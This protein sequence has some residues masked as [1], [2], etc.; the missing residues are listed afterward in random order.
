[1]N[2]LYRL[3]LLLTALLVAD[4]VCAQSNAPTGLTVNVTY[5]GSICL[6]WKPNVP[7][8]TVYEIERSPNGRSGSFIKV[9]ES[10]AVAGGTLAV[11][12]Y[13]DENLPSNTTYYYQVRGKTGTTFTG[14]SNTTPGTTKA[15]PPT[16]AAPTLSEVTTTDIKVTW[17]TQFATTYELE[18][19]TGGGAWRVINTQGSGRNSSL[20]YK[21]TTLSG[22]VNY[23]FRVRAN[24]AQEGTSGYSP[25]ACQTTLQAASNVRNFAANANGSSNSIK[26]T[27]DRYGKESGITIERRTG[28][29]GAWDKSFN[30]LADGGE[31]TDTGLSAGTEYCYRIQESG[32]TVS[33]TKCAI[34]AQLVPEPPRNLRLT[35][36]SSQKITLNWDQSP[37]T[38]AN[39]YYIEV[40]DNQGGNYTRLD[41]VNGVGTTQYEHNGLTPSKQYCYRVKTKYNNTLSNPSNERCETTQA[42]PV[43]VPRPPTELALQG[44]TDKQITLRWKDNSDNETNFTIERSTDG[45]RTWQVHKTLDRNMTSYDD[46]GLNANSQY[47]Y[48]VFAYN[49]AGNSGTTS[50]ECATTQAPPVVIPAAPTELALQVVND[51]QIT[52]RWKDNSDNEANFAIERS[53]DG[54]RTWQPYK[55]VDRNTTSYDDGGLNASTEYCYRVYAYNTASNS[56]TTDELCN[57]TQAP[58]VTTPV[59][60]TEL[61][62]QVVNDKQITLRWKDNSDNETGFSIERSTDGK[63][64]WQPHKNVDRN[65]TS[66][67]D[68][69]LNAST[70]YCYRVFAYNTAGNSGTTR[71][72]CA[73]TQAPPVTAP[74]PPTELALQVIN[75]KQ[76][77]L[78]W[79]DNSDNE[80]GFTIERS[81]D[82]KRTWQPHKT[83]DRNTTS[84]DDSGLNASTEYCYRVYAY[85]TAGNSRPTDELCNTTQAPPVTAPAAPSGLKATATSSTEIALTWTDNSPNETRFELQR[86]LTGNDPWENVDA[87][88]PADTK[89]KTDGGR[90]PSTRYWYRV[91]AVL[92][93]VT[94]AALSSEWS[95]IANDITQ[96]PPLTPPT[97]P[98]GLKAEA[99]PTSPDQQITVSWTDNSTNESGFE[100]WQ[101]ASQ[102]APFTKIADV[103][104]DKTSYLHTGL[105]ASTP[106]CYQVRAVNTAGNSPFVG[107][108]CT[109]TQAPPLTAPAPPSDFNASAASTSVINLSWKD[110]SLTETGFDLQWSATNADPWTS[111]P[112]Q[113]SNVTTFAHTG[114]SPNTRYY[115]RLRAVN[116]AGPSVWVTANTSTPALPVPSTTAD[117]EAKVF[118]YDQIKLTWGAITNNP[119]S[120]VVER[121]TSPTG[122]F[123]QVGQPLPGTA[124]TF[125][126]I[127]LPELTTFY[128]RIRSTNSFGQSGNSNVAFAKTPE[129]IISVRPMPLPEGI[130][131]HVDHGTLFVTLNWNQFQEAKLRVIGLDGREQLTDQCRINGGTLFQYDVARLPG[132]VYVLCLDT[133]KNRFTKKI[134]IP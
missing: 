90:N 18:M 134:W 88:I 125:T 104:P 27:W 120:I 33:E 19:Q 16:P 70:E 11:G 1:M 32:H 124:T 17:N 8:A 61:A 3:V 22:G 110:N 126:D 37:S 75:D 44:I 10:A 9:G 78:R 64:T 46:G 89:Q 119:T 39:G 118:D 71:E 28:Q 83:V 63:R 7:A 77:T 106:Y 127:G 6:Q 21:I 102:T 50:E 60:P 129:A 26:L 65:T 81:T 43:T 31:Y 48:R 109:A 133:D 62:L 38:F 57:T 128:Y 80:T 23:C 100:V 58:P 34:T 41:E 114:L 29:N 72:E 130:Y 86:S 73:T 101:A 14:Y 12:N 2:R 91:R 99:G 15:A 93:T 79:K 25:N 52:I 49:T 69:G 56:R 47:C 97:A 20:S 123:T 131:A 94:G 68:G 117:L 67:D 36:N 96:A 85:N 115:Y 4:R 105:T 54:K 42:P 35:V 5:G 74:A 103:G 116:S 59:P 55:T 132:G 87:N 122:S 108:V 13:C 30:T 107:P 111:L 121:A 112:T 98:S 53:T 24:D 45:K 76:I 95:N 82:G 113:T 66:Y 84:Y 51:K 40:A 92:V